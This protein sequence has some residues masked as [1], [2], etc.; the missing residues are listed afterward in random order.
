MTV[1]WLCPVENQPKSTCL[2]KI[3]THNKCNSG[4][5]AS[6]LLKLSTASQMRV[7]PK[8]SNTSLKEPSIMVVFPVF[9]ALLLTCPSCAA[10]LSILQ[11]FL[12]APAVR[13]QVI[14]C[15]W[16]PSFITLFPVTSHLSPLT[17]NICVC[18]S[19]PWTVL[20]QTSHEVVWIVSLV[21]LTF[22]GF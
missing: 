11:F 15:D 1:I 17:H 21:F 22:C 7:F 20:L 4:L 5:F 12:S 2:A 13:Q 19:H 18:S 10:L 8:V 3:W 9:P 6:Q 14:D 16:S